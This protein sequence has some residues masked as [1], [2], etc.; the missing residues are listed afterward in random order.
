MSDTVERRLVGKII[1]PDKQ[2]K[3]QVFALRDNPESITTTM[4]T[5]WPTDLPVDEDSDYRLRGPI[6]NGVKNDFGYLLVDNVDPTDNT[7][8]KAFAANPSLFA[9]LGYNYSKNVDQKGGVTTETVTLTH[10]T[11][12]ALNHKFL[13]IFPE[14]PLRFVEFPP[15]KYHPVDFMRGYIERGEVLV[16]GDDIYR[17]HDHYALHVLGFIGLSGLFMSN[18]RRQLNPIL[19]REVAENSLPS[20]PGLDKPKIDLLFHP[21]AYFLE[22]VAKALDRLTNAVPYE[23]LAGG[24]ENHGVSLLSPVGAVELEIENFF[25]SDPIPSGVLTPPDQFETNLTIQDVRAI[26]KRIQEPI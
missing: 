22:G 3:F 9:N 20:V 13:H 11:V 6:R 16:G 2:V 18:L 10:P 23:L 4:Q 25:R 8:P 15:G 5:S 7:F 14:S 21:S 17:V 19:A 24:G 12:S 1:S 26:Y